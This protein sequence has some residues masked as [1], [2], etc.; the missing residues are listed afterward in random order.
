[1]ARPAAAGLPNHAGRDVAGIAGYGFG[2]GVDGVGEV[3]TGQETRYFSTFQLRQKCDIIVA[4]LDNFFRSY[5][6]TSDFITIKDAVEE[7]GGEDALAY[8]FNRQRARE[9]REARNAGQETIAWELWETA[10]KF[11]NQVADT[12]RRRNNAVNEAMIEEETRKFF[13]RQADKQDRK[14]SGMER[15]RE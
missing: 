13:G 9:I 1:M 3:K 14:S 11:D 7:C 6:M 4:G 10:C 8:V 2:G 5:E 12:N 15:W